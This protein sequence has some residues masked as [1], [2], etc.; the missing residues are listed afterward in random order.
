MLIAMMMK[1]THFLSFC[2]AIC[3]ALLALFSCSSPENKLIGNWVTESVSV[4][5]DSA[6]AYL[7][8]VDATIAST[9]AMTFTLHDDHTMTLDIDGYITNAFW[10]YDKDTKMVSYRLKE[11]FEQDEYNIGKLEDGKIINNSKLKYGTIT[12]VHVKD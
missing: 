3:I 5:V 2:M 10:L 8:G 7:P 6:K 11:E 1:T 12:S 4:S 9:K